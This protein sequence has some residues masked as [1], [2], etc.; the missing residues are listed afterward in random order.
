MLAE[1][2]KKFLQQNDPYCPWQY[3]SKIAGEG[4]WTLNG[5]SILPGVCKDLPRG[6][7]TQVV[8]R[9]SIF[10]SSTCT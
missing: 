4:A 9:E 1:P 6:F 8:L 7:R 10:I 2:L 5:G 3:C